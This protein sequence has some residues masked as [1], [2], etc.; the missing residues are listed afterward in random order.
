MG[1][2]R[3]FGGVLACLSVLLGTSKILSGCDI[4]I[5]TLEGFQELT[6]KTCKTPKVG[7]VPLSKRPDHPSITHALRSI[8]CQTH[9]PM[10]TQLFKEMSLENSVH[11]F[12]SWNN[13][14][15]HQLIWSPFFCNRLIN[16]RI[17][18]AALRNN[19]ILWVLNPKF[20]DL[21][22]ICGSS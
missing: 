14:I 13:L 22:R 5:H 2:L 19:Y 9:G 17:C 3:C 8:S 16:E 15:Q 12:V 7:I 10:F 6:G 20:S 18:I 1:A 11:I 4:L 21:R